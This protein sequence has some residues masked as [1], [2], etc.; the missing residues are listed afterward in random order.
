MGTRFPHVIIQMLHISTPAARFGPAVHPQSFANYLLDAV[1][2]RGRKTLCESQFS[3]KDSLVGLGKRTQIGK[4]GGKR[5]Y[6][7]RILLAQS[8]PPL[9]LIFKDFKLFF[10]R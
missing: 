5:P 1:E 3:L 8:P 6:P 4:L 9:L 7:L 2:R 10:K